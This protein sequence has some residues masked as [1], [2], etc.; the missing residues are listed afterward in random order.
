MQFHCFIGPQ[1][2]IFFVKKKIETRRNSIGVSLELIVIK[3]KTPQVA[4][5]IKE[6]NDLTSTDTT[7]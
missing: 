3:R 1:L 6:V 5:G 4:N 7:T 2:K